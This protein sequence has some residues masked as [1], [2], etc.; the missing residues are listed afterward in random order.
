MEFETKRLAIKKFIPE[1][2]GIMYD[3]WATDDEVLRYMPEYKH[4]WSIDEFAETIMRGYKN[5]SCKYM[6]IQKIESK[7]IIGLVS[8]YQEDSSSK[9]VN[10]VIIKDEWNK[11]YATEVLKSIIKTLKKQK[12]ECIYA[13]CDGRNIGAN[14]VCEKCKFEL[15]DKIDNYRVD[16]DGVLGVEYLYELEL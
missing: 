13:T 15:I 4:D 7:E 3:T 11:G 10:I 2:I 16:I 6:L 14:R 1:Y 12:I 5:D 9:S 8:L